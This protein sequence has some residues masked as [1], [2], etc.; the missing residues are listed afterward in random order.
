MEYLTLP[1]LIA[2]AALVLGGWV[3]RGFV[4]HRQDTERARLLDNLQS[5][6][7]R[8]NELKAPGRTPEQIAEEAREAALLAA[9]K[10][11]VQTVR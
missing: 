2:A 8:L 9:I 7:R 10:E 5:A 11:E 4:Q 3:A 6:I 1:A